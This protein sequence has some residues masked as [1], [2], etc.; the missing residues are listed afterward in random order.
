MHFAASVE[1]G[2]NRT[3]GSAAQENQRFATVKVGTAGQTS[4]PEQSSDRLV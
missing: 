4:H 3:C 2:S 1:M